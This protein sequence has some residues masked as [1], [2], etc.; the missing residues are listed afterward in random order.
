[1]GLKRQRFRAQPLRTFKAA[2][3]RPVAFG[4]SGGPLMSDDDIRNSS[5]NDNASREPIVC[6]AHAAARRLGYVL[7]KRERSGDHFIIVNPSINGVIYGADDL[8][9]EQVVEGCEAHFIDPTRD[10]GKSVVD[11]KSL[12]EWLV[13][14][15]TRTEGTVF[16]A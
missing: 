8:T 14:R 9:A 16:S 6:R 7:R 1:M 13:A 4:F 5:D 3:P 15:V 10:I 2:G 12:R 11:V